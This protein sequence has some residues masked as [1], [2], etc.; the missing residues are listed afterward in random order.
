M[1]HLGIVD[2]IDGEDEDADATVDEVEELD[3]DAHQGED[4][5]EQAK[6]DKDKEDAEEDAAAH[7]EINLGL[8]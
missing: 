5:H 2:E 4:C 6:E 8:K 7:C 1:H 3:V